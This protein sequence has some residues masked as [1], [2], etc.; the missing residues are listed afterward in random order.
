[1]LYLKFEL[2]FVYKPFHKVNQ[3]KWD[4]DYASKRRWETENL[5]HSQF[6]HFGGK[7]IYAF[8]NF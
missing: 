7:I 5:G 4:D 1:M 2:V 6:A 3:R 8:F